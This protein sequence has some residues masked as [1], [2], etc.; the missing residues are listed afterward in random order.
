MVRQVV[1]FFP[2]QANVQRIFLC[3][4]LSMRQ[5]AK[6]KNGQRNRFRSSFELRIGVLLDAEMDLVRTAFAQIAGQRDHHKPKYKRG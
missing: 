5:E 1:A 2:E 6:D 3:T 4:C